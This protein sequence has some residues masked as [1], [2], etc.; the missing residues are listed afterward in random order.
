MVTDT[1]ADVL[2][3]IRNAQRRGHR[4]VRVPS[5]KMAGRLLEVLKSEGFILGFEGRRDKADRFDEIEVTLKYYQSGEPGI[6]LLRRVSTPGRRVY[7][8]SA[9][10]PRVNSG[11]GISILS[12]PQGVM[13]DRRARKLGVGG[14]VLALV[15]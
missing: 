12:T 1:I 9:K 8:K 11:L 10:V 5:S 7:S 3:R 14:E 4:G 13:S 2:T 6:R 15:G